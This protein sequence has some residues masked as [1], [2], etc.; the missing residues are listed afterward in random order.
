MVKLKAMKEV[1]NMVRVYTYSALSV[2]GDRSWAVEIDV[3]AEGKK[4]ILLLTLEEE[5][6]LYKALCERRRLGS[7]GH[8]VKVVVS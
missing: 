2:A 1:V 5:N 3:S 8:D 6:A 4:K 7:R